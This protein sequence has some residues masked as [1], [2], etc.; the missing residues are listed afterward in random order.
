MALV[1]GEYTRDSCKVKRISELFLTVLWYN[2]D[3]MDD[4]GL[5]EE[6]ASFLA[7]KA[8]EGLRPRSVDWYRERLGR[9]LGDLGLR[10]AEVH[11]GRP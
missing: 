2:K 11:E 7:H 8:A 3:V 10:R 1:F 9:V 5:P 6:L 4:G